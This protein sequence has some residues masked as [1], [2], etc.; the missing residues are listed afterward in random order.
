MPNVQNQ[1]AQ[2]KT[3]A[4]W[5]Y[6]PLASSPRKT[7][8]L[9]VLLVCA[10]VLAYYWFQG[11]GL[12]MAIFFTIGPLSGYILPSDYTLTTYGVEVKNLVHQQRFKWSKFVDYRDYP[13]AMQLYFDPRNLRGL[14]LKGVLLFYNENGE[15]I[16]VVVERHLEPRRD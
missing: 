8:L 6:H 15:Q 11:W 5:S 9:G 7:V 4:S 10:W 2:D 14:L 1:D 3:L 13:D 16:R 12:F